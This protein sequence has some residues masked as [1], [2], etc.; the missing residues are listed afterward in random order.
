M[1]AFVPPSMAG[2]NAYYN[3]LTTKYYIKAGDLFKITIGVAVLIIA[4]HLIFY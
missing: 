3:D 1:R 4:L 2:I